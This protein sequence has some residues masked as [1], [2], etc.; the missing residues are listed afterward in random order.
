MRILLVEDEAKTQAFLKKGL[1]EQGYVVDS[2][3]DGVEGLFLADTVHFDLII[4]D[5]M[6]PKL[7]GWQVIQ[8][9][10]Q[11]NKQTPVLFLTA[12][13]SIE[14]R[15]KGLQLG[16]DDYLVKPFAFSELMARI[17][18]LLRRGQVHQEEVLTIADMEIDCLRHKVKRDGNII[19]LTQKEFALLSLLAR[20]KGE[21]MSRTMI[22]EQVWD[23]N[24]DSDTNIIDVAIRRLRQKVDNP[25]DTKLI[26]TARGIG[27]VLEAR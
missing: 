5:V 14:D 12:R 6:L 11:K 20:R 7:N 18:S 9:L 1:T 24:F 23:M 2:A 27:Y 3:A 15:V 17:H 16:A 25:Y 19:E 21:V 4:L 13:D 10:R 8:E 26:H 22:A